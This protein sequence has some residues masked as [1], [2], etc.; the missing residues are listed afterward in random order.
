[1]AYKDR[2]GGVYCISSIVDGKQYI[3]STSLLLLRWSNHRSELNRGKSGH[4][5]LQEAWSLHGRASFEFTVLE[6]I[7]D[8]GKLK[9]REQYWVDKLNPEYNVCEL[10]DSCRGVT[11]SA[12]TREKLAAHRRGKKLSQ[13]SIQ[14]R[15]ATKKAKVIVYR[16]GFTLSKET[17]EKCSLALRGVGN[18]NSIL[19]DD[20]VIEIYKRAYYGLESQSTI[21]NDFGIPQARVSG[22]LLGKNW[23]HVTE[24]LRK[25]NPPP[26]P[27]NYKNKKRKKSLHASKG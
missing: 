22:I 21:A 17:K 2:R 1:M 7:E 24:E 16:R 12:E 19:T 8:K 9:A 27:G 25:A 26:I 15:E 14:K 6:Y 11:R 13:D 4:P 18:P 23:K 5:R 3:G 10:T 20:K